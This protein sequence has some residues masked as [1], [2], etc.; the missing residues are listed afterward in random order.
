[1]IVIIHKPMSEN[2][3]I[4]LKKLVAEVHA[5]AVSEKL[6]SMSCSKEI[7]LSMFK[8]INNNNK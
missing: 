2:A 8:E 1:M 3:K 5:K 6:K 4:E 7:V